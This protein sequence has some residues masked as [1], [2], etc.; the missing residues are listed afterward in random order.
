[1]KVPAY[2][3]RVGGA[4]VMALTPLSTALAGPLLAGCYERTYDARYLKAHK[5]QIVLRVRLAVTAPTDPAMTKPLIA[6]APLTIWVSTVKHAFA[7]S[8]VCRASGDGLLCNGAV[9]ATET[10]TCPNKADG[11]RNC[12]I[13]WPQSAG[14]FQVD[15]RPD[16]VL[17]SIPERLEIP[18]PN[19]TDG[20]PFLY[21]SAGNVENHEFRLKSVPASRC[22]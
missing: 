15:P 4:L 10:E 5:G 18:G 21:L 12:R 14:S 13:D 2:L 16:G 1:M 20:L 8:G 17:V 6:E 3:W 19:A 22:K 11:V 7:T 9:A